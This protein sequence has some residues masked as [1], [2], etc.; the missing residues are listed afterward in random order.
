MLESHNIT[1]LT[2][3][4][5]C[6]LVLFLAYWAHTCVIKPS[7]HIMGKQTVKW[8]ISQNLTLLCVIALCQGIN[9]LFWDVMNWNQVSLPSDREGMLVLQWERCHLHL[10]CTQTDE[11]LGDSHLPDHIQTQLLISPAVC[12]GRPWTPCLKWISS[13]LAR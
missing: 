5:A 2:C 12:F 13:S 3:M 6:V 1:K 11:W 7:S 4:K 8:C 9:T 10:T